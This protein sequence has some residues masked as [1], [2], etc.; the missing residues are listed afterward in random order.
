MT[1]HLA[2]SST[3]GVVLVSDSQGSTN[4]AEYHGNQK[5]FAGEDFLIGAAGSGDI[6]DSLFSSLQKSNV[7]SSELQNYITEFAKNNWTTAA[8]ES[9]HLTI[10]IS[11]S[12]IVEYVPR[13]YRN[14]RERRQFSV[15]GSGAE[16]VVREVSFDQRAGLSPPAATTISDLLAMCLKYFSASN[17]SLTV[18][19]QL[20]IGIL[21]NNRSYLLIDPRIRP[22]YL[23]EKL[24]SVLPK[25]FH[26]F[27]EVV[28]IVSTLRSE[29]LNIQRALTPLTYGL[30]KTALSLPIGE[31]TESRSVLNK[32]IADYFNWYDGIMARQ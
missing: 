9:I 16:F 6:A 3:F 29:I 1:C 32:K 12:T 31:I 22:E 14:F 5:Q 30:G 13:L 18:D 11:P 7:K 8:H 17:E 24:Q 4:D 27:R 26:N 25:I 21:H 10:A 28:A 23:P 20:M 15:I 2:M 19:D